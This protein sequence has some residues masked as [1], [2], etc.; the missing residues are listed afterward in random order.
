MENRNLLI[1]RLK[2][3]RESR[4]YPFHMPGHKRLAGVLEKENGCSGFDF[5]NPF[6]VDITEIEGFDN[7]HHPEGIL[8]ESMEW[9][10]SVY[11]AGRTW[12]L[13]NGSSCGIL[14]A[15]SAAAG[16]NTGRKGKILMARNCHKA[17][18]HGAYLSGLEVSYLYPQFIPEL[19]IQGG[20]LPEDVEK[21]LEME[22]ESRAVLLVSPTYDGVV[23]DIERIAQIVHKR[24]IPLI[25][26]EAHGAHFPFGEEFPVSALELGA[27]VVIQSVHKTLPSLTQ[28]AVLHLNRNEAV[29]GPFVDEGRL[30]R[31]LSIYQSSSPSYLLMASI[32]H[33]V[34]QMDRERN[35][36]GREDSWLDAYDRRLKNLRMGLSS[37]K[38]LRLG[39][40]AFGECLKG[41]RG[42]YDLDLSK[43]V[44]SAKGTGWTGPK[45]DG[46]LR[47]EYGL[48][49]EMCG[50]DYVLGITTCFDSEEGLLRLKKALLE[51]DERIEREMESG[52]KRL[53]DGEE[54]GAVP[55][56]LRRE[57]SLP[58]AKI[59]LSLRE[60][61]DGAC[62]SIPLSEAE[63][64]VSGEFVYVYPPGIP[65]L[66]PGEEVTD[67]ILELILEYQKRGLPVQ[68]PQDH[69][70]QYLKVIDRTG[71]K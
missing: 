5:P 31:F 46:L 27:D 49:M 3:Y 1:N 9:A 24:N 57:I 23:S 47:K 42:I 45:L 55:E 37:M 32:E 17:A 13:V 41:S 51:L 10:A 7:L 38:T 66:A 30:E 53:K 25:V 69:S 67:S 68:G 2:D 43:I 20:I 36:R 14:S 50:A 35:S 11:G 39:G 63:G 12:Y 22:P 56:Y 21:A 44:I 18:Y 16:E 58:R 59:C 52:Q 28:T 15:I 40:G 64:S 48:E 29:G 54:A 26:D 60:G 19:G 71:I 62:R 33:A 70:L 65:I 61:M 34:F 6:L 8:K 4:M